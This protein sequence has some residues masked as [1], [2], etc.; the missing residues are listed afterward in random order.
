MFGPRTSA[1]G[2]EMPAHPYYT[3]LQK[4]QDH[5]PDAEPDLD[6]RDPVPH[7][8][9]IPFEQPTSALVEKYCYH[10]CSTD[11][12]GG[13][14]SRGLKYN[15]VRAQVGS[16]SGTCAEFGIGPLKR[17]ASLKQLI[18][19]L[20]KEYFENRAPAFFPEEALPRLYLAL[21]NPNYE[22]N[23]KKKVEIWARLLVQMACIA[24]SSCVTADRCPK[25][26]KVKFP[27]N[28]R[29][30]YSDG[31]PHY[32]DLVWNKWKSRPTHHN[33]RDYHIRLYANPFDKTFCPVHWLFEHWTD[34]G[35]FDH[36]E[37]A[38]KSPNIILGIFQS[39]LTSDT[40]RNTLRTLFHKAGYKCSS[41]SIRRSAAMWASRCG[42]GFDVIKDIGR[43]ASS[44]ELSKYLAEGRILEERKYADDEVG[45][46]LIGF[47]ILDVHTRSDTM[48]VMGTSAS[49]LRNAEI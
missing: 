38:D 1:D 14:A 27:Q 30:Y 25:F 19:K 42:L 26:H 28:K 10:L 22:V 23:R 46:H 20:R 36:P 4:L 37:N 2:T 47:W 13:I 3:F 17:A 24:R 35:H 12:I 40:W 8:F 21:F 11:N 32:V 44:E 16:L 34:S 49:V 45:D 43:W 29:S 15:A 9:T 5:I 39:S 18:E 6:G 33:H 7:E 41:H 31:L 48:S